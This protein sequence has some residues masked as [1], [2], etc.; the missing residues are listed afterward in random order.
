M[1]VVGFI[2]LICMLGFT[3][4]WAISG[5][6]DYAILFAVIASLWSYIMWLNE[7]LCVK[8]NEP[9]VVVTK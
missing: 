3:I 4:V 6:L 5:W 9:K 8:S 1:R 2:V 7:K